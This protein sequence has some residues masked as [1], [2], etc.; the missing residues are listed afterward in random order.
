MKRLALIL[1]TLMI[2]CGV[3]GPDTYYVTKTDTPEGP[4]VVDFMSLEVGN[5]WEYESKDFY[6]MPDYFNRQ[7]IG[8]LSLVNSYSSGDTTF[9]TATV[10]EVGIET[11]W[12][13]I[14]P[15][16]VWDTIPADTTFTVTF[17]IAGKIVIKAY[18]PYFPVLSD[19]LV[20]FP[21]IDSVT[22]RTNNAG[23][24]SVGLIYWDYSYLTLTGLNIIEAYGDK[25]KKLLSFN[26]NPVDVDTT[27]Y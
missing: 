10:R 27:L 11:S 6:A 4:N 12:H 19:T 25:S 21:D 18:Y 16:I 1:L 24:K 9:Y 15:Q 7:F 3:T 20:S 26:G 14:D 5:V 17:S 8:A 22:I 13:W 2:N 23:Q